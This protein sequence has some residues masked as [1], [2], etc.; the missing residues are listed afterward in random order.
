MSYPGYLINGKRY[1]TNDVERCTQDYGISV[2]AQTICR[3]S[4]RDTAHV[5]AD[6]SYYGI[7]REIIVLD[8]HT[9]RFPVSRCNWPNIVTGVKEDE[10]FTLVNLH[11]GLNQLQRDPFILAS[12]AKQVLYSRENESS[13]WYVVLKAPPRGFHELDEFDENEYTTYA[14]HDVH[15]P[16]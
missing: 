12:Q 2:D 1:H 4:A 15:M 7:I 3:S 10:G 6:I 14:Q 11:D 9:F 16:R 8:F 5:Q 13:S